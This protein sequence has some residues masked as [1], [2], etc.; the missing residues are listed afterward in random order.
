MAGMPFAAVAQKLEERRVCRMEGE[1]LG[2][3]VWF[4]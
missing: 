4:C 3:I 1:G 2:L